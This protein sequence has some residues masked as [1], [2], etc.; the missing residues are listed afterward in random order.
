MAVQFALKMVFR[1]LS[2][3]LMKEYVEARE[4]AARLTVDDADHPNVDRLYE[5]WEAL[6]GEVR[7]KMD[8]DQLAVYEMD[9]SDT[10]LSTVLEE[11]AHLVHD[12]AEELQ[13]VFAK[14][15]S[16]YDRMLHNSYTTAESLTTR[17]CLSRQTA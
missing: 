3:P 7:D 8:A 2:G 16:P 17:R 10:A 12:K 6:P 11:A 14:L 4:H 1:Y 15:E 13:Q 9:N 5:Q